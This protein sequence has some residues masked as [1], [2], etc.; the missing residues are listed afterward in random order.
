MAGRRLGQHFLVRQSILERIASAA[1]PFPDQPI[2]EVGPGKGA[3]TQ[4]L[5]K[6]AARVHAIEVDQVLVHYLQEKFRNEANFAVQHSDVLKA[7]LGQWGPV[8]VAGNLPYYITSPILERVLAL[9]PKLLHAVFLIQKEVADRVVAA[10][11]SRDYGYLS[12][13]V[14]IYAEPKYLFTVPPDAFKPPPQVDS[15][16][17]E[18]RPRAVPLTEDPQGLVKFAGLCFRQKR[19]MLRNNLAGS[20]PNEAILAQPEARLRAEQLSVLQLADLRDRILKYQ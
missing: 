7:D 17:V 9:G 10:P 15:A 4:Y 2:V 11:G 12:V 3:L 16:V 20:F 6:R 19:K 13:Q 5:I 14:Q 8:Q 1:C 18:L